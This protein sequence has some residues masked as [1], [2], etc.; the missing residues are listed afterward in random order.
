[1]PSISRRQFISRVAQGTA[2]LS[3]GAGL[4]LPLRHGQA[5][6]D[7]AGKVGGKTL[8]L[9]E[10]AGGNDGLNTIVPFRDELYYKHRPVLGIPAKSVL[11]LDDRFGLNPVLEPLAPFWNAGE[12]A[13]VHGVGYPNPSLSHFR[14]L[15]IWHTARPDIGEG[16][17]G[18]GWLGRAVDRMA[19]ELPVA[20][21][22]PS[23]RV[24]AV[25]SPASYGPAGVS[26]R[27]TNAMRRLSEPPAASS[28]NAA[29]DYLR[30]S[31]G[32]AYIAADQLARMAR[33]Y[34][35]K[36]DY[37]DT[38]IGQAFKA[39]A[40]ILAA[41][42][43]TRAVYLTLGGFDT[44]AGQQVAQPQLLGWVAGG[45]S[46]FLKD[47]ALQGKANDVVVMVYSEFGRRVKENESYGTDH[48]S[49]GPVLL[50]GKGVKGGFV[51][52][53]PRLDALEDG[54]LVHSTDFRRL[55][56][57]LLERWLG[58]PAHPILGRGYEALPVLA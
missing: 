46:A 31:A 15:E 7:E 40:Q 2:F 47:V 24:A 27:E 48:G 25:E 43:G 1:M 42:L 13:V 19:G 34:K 21:R 55:Y 6:A 12:M 29:L 57:T 28:G 58:V 41:G 39:T 52:E 5:F 53:P 49:A 9:L 4:P 22:S 36:A 45:L 10:L 54:N 37:P 11:K 26:D 33:D 32:Q 14:S 51:G 20:M 38:G 3:L 44:H 35:A 23:A 17:E 56:A 18:Y 8:V 16:V 50:F 30:R